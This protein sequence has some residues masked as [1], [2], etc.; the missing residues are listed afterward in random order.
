MA[1]YVDGYVLP[2]PKKNMAAYTRMAK[3]G[4]KLWKKHGALEYFECIGDDLTTKM[5]VTFPKQMK[6][7]GSETI[8]FSFIVFKSRK[9]RDAVNEKVMKDP[10]LSALMMGVKMPFDCQRMVYGGFKVLVE[11]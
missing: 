8:V 9:H 10:A 6:S 11:A 2:V 7:K 4:A 5:G 1:R 3:G